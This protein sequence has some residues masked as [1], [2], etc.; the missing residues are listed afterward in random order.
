VIMADGKQITAADLELKPTDEESEI[1]SFDLREVREV[2][3]RQVITKALNHTNGKVSP[4]AELL[5][6]SRPT[7]Y[8]LMQKLNIQI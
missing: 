6:V 5:G 4:A 1:N 8:D 2:A 7:L 3:E